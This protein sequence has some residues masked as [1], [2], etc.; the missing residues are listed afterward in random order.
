MP[1]LLSP[2]WGLGLNRSRGFTQG[3]DN[4]MEMEPCFCNKLSMKK[5]AERPLESC[6]DIKKEGETLLRDS[7]V[8]WYYNELIT[9]F[10]KHF[11]NSKRK[12]LSPKK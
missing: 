3:G 10:Q 11:K 2:C 8:I 5:T 7:D 1:A 4:T 9:Q 6:L 12:D